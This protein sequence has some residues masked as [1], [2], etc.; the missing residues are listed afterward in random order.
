MDRQNKK[1]MTSAYRDRRVI[2]GVCAIKNTVN[3]KVL[4]S[5]VTDLQGYRN[6]YEFIRSTN[7]CMDVR[8]QNDWKRYGAG[9][10]TFEVLEELEKK[11]SQTA[12]EFSND[13]KTLKDIWLEKFNPDRLY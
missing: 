6:R 8:L 13:I 11:D 7:G 10:F 2:G 9:A 4:I 1:E 12:G 5:A 3:G